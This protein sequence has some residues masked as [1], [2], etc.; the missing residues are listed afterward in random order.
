MPKKILHI[1]EVCNG[2]MHT[3]LSLCFPKAK[4][5]PQRKDYTPQSCAILSLRVYKTGR[6][7]RD[8]L[9]AKQTLHTLMPPSN[10][11]IIA[12][13]MMT[14]R[15]EVSHL[16]IELS[17]LRKATEKGQKSF[18]AV[19]TVKQDVTHIKKSLHNLR[20]TSFTPTP[21]FSQ[22]LRHNTTQRPVPPQQTPS[23]PATWRTSHSLRDRPSQARNAS[24]HDNTSVVS[25]TA[26]GHTLNYQHD[27]SPNIAQGNAPRQNMNA[28]GNF[29]DDPSDDASRDIPEQDEDGWNIIR[30][31]TR[32]W[33]RST[34]INGN[35]NTAGGEFSGVDRNLD[36]FIGVSNP[37]TSEDVIVNHVAT[38]K[39]CRQSWL[40]CTF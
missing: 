38:K 23:L 32:H 33:K 16:R 19:S 40:V 8:V 1:V 6:T 30:N 37:N 35:I 5:E 3:L 2:L 36:V 13:Y 29:A 17:E 31:N 21:S 18:E 25:Q 28:L 11:E 22:T 39:N 34:Q 15:D 7:V 14:L 12:P 10:F 4:N 20:T 26:A 9:P 24:S 27:G